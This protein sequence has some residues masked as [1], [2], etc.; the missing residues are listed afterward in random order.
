MI[1][2]HDIRV[3][4]AYVFMMFIVGIAMATTDAAP[5]HVVIAVVCGATAFVLGRMYEDGED[6]YH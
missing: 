3:Y 5:F 1:K 2:K 6:E 4:I